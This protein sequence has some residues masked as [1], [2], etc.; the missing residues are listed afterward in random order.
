MLTAEDYPNDPFAL[1]RVHKTLASAGKSPTKQTIKN[2]FHSYNPENE[3]ELTQ[4]Q[5]VFLNEYLKC[6]NAS[7]AA[8]KAGYS[9]NSLR[10][11]AH[12][13]LSK[14]YIQEVIQDRLNSLKMSADE[15]LVAL[16]KIARSSIEDFVDIAPSGEDENGEQLAPLPLPN[17]EKAQ[18]RGQLDLVKKMSWN[19][20]RFSFELYDK[21]SALNTIA[22]HHGLLKDHVQIDVN[23][24]V[25]VV[26]ALQELGQDP[27][28]VFREI[29]QRAN[30]RHGSN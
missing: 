5:E 18:Q 14:P 16:S 21:Q 25:Q 20:G 28:T 2:W 17:F 12:E 22:K 7:E 3:N 15:S 13:T 11:I 10:Q 1:G 4:K 6:W 19:K 29:I 24:I 30:A 27:E 9:E 8:R 26:D 23:L